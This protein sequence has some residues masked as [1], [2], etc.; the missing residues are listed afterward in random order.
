MRQRISLQFCL[1]I[2]LFTRSSNEM[3]KMSSP[4]DK[5][6]KKQKKNVNLVRNGI[7]ARVFGIKRS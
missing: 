2:V 3:R 4:I 5:T 7:W 1:I 6:V